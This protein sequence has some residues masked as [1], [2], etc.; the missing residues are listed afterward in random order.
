MTNDLHDF[1]QRI[2]SDEAIIAR[3]YRM[4]TLAAY[5][6]AVGF[7]GNLTF[8]VLNIAHSGLDHTILTRLGVAAFTGAMWFTAA[9]RCFLLL[10]RNL[11]A[12]ALALLR[13][14]TDWLPSPFSNTARVVDRTTGTEHS[15]ELLPAPFTFSK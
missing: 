10:R 5:I 13:S 11:R 12:P 9:L 2:A 3:A 14:P 15:V 7:I 8:A 6:A 4:N 1:H